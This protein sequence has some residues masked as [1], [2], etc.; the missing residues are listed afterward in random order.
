MSSAHYLLL[1]DSNRPNRLTY[2][3][4]VAAQF[5]T[6]DYSNGW[7]PLFWF[8]EEYIMTKVTRRMN[9]VYDLFMSTIYSCPH[10]NMR[11]YFFLHNALPQANIIVTWHV[12]DLKMWIG[13]KQTSADFIYGDVVNQQSCAV[14]LSD[15]GFLKLS[16]LKFLKAET[17][18][19]PS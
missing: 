17:I 7:I 2:V 11:S 9:G 14:I 15:T 5:P 6:L 10:F 13:Y 4:T 16:Y 3:H 12:S 18:L 19:K 8:A 1:I